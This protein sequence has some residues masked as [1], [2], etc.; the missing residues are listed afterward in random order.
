M[1]GTNYE[2]PHCGDISNP[3]RHPAWAQIFA[4]GSY[5]EIPLTWIPPLL[6]ETM[7]RNHVAQLKILL[8]HIF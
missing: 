8:F 6:K 1:N 3:H 2:V 5:F 4:S 7:F